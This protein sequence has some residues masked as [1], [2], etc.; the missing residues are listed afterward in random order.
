M[1]QIWKRE[2]SRID[3]GDLFGWDEKGHYEH[4]VDGDGDWGDGD[5]S[6]NVI[7]G[8]GNDIGNL[9]WWGEKGCCD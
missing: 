9:F 8:S 6:D 7:V 2:Y 3:C 5:W 4:N 1:F